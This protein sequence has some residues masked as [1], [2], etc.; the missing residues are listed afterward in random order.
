MLSKNKGDLIY[1]SDF[2]SLEE[3]LAIGQKDA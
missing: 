1:V 2:I 3:R